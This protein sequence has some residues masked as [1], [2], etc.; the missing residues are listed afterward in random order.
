M[1]IEKVLNNNMVISRN[2]E[3]KEIILQGK[4]IG[5]NKR[6]RDSIVSTQVERILHPMTR[7]KLR[8]FR[9]FLQSCRMNIGRSRSR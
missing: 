9:T 6:K 8:G 7:M 1:V 2:P 4:G 5:F 3:G